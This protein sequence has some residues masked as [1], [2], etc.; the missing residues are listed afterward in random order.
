VTARANDR[1]TRRQLWLFVGLV[2]VLGIACLVWSVNRIATSASSGIGL[3]PVVLT[4]MIAVANSSG[5]RVRV[6]ASIF[7]FSVTSSAV[8]VAAVVEPVEW[9][10]VCAAAGVLISNLSN[11]SGRRSVE[12]TAFNV[13]K[14]SVAATAAAATLLAFAI[15]PLTVAAE[16]E[17]MPYRIF[18]MFVA[19][20]VYL[21]I[22]E[23]FFFPVLSSATGTP[24]RRLAVAHLDVRLVMRLAAFLL[25]V[26]TTM[27][28][29]ANRGLLIA[30]P[31]LLYALQLAAKGRV[32]SR[33]EREAWQNL[34]RSTDELNEVDLDRVLRSAIVRA[35]ELFSVDEVEVELAE[36]D[37]VR[38]RLVRGGNH[39][40][41]YDGPP[42][43][44]PA[45]K[46]VVIA[47]ELESHGGGGAVGEL[48]LRFRGKVKLSDR[49]QYTLHTFAAA[50]C[51]AI[52][53]AAAYAETQRLAESHA[54]AASQDPLTGLANRRRLYEYGTEVL[55]RRPARGIAGLLL[56]D[57]NHF[58]E[59]NDT[60]GHSAGDR[61]LQ[62][63]ARRLAAA[64]STEDLVARLGGDEFAVLL[65]GLPAPAVA[66][67]RAQ[68]MLA[69]LAPPVELD[70]MRI[71]VEA[72]AGVATA[73]SRG[74]VV[75]LLRRADV[76]MYQAKRDGQKVCAY[77][78]ARDTADVGS[79]ALGGDLARAVAEDQ[80][81]VNF[82]PIV[83]LGTGE[84]I[85]AEALTRWHHP[86]RG[87][88]PP[89][90]FLDAIE[91]SGRLPAFAEAVLDQAL[92][93]AAGWRA[94]GF[95]IPVAVNVSPRSL[96]DPAFPSV[97]TGR[98][99]AHR[100]PAEALVVELTESLTLSQ[101]DV[102]DEVLGAL[103][104][105]GVVLALD[106]FGTGYSSL[107][108]LARVPVHELKI[109]R[110]FVASMD[111]PVA[112]AVVRST[113]ELGR[114]LDLLVVAEGVESEEQRKKLW[115]LGCPAGQ[116]HLFARPMPADRLITALHRGS[117][118]R[119]GTLAP[120]LH[121]A[122][123]VIRMPTSRRGRPPSQ[124]LDRSG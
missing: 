53:N 75:E 15:P 76:A 25:A 87:D 63:V 109:D 96:L 124:R 1:A 114:S 50:L 3:Y 13:A 35:A 102:V 22:D 49:E 45:S 43:R 72:S 119:P 23:L 118:G 16:L 78:R 98:L 100:L 110:S 32:Q 90:R 59:V 58:K 48:R 37:I 92:T 2:V 39:G 94:E 51:T 80:F 61:V 82:Q 77:A 29:V 62:E 42:E 89:D 10:S 60:L 111:S 18:A 8:L 112:A 34:A 14:E 6:R 31:F 19:A 44:A 30:L 64:A 66:L 28:I 55:A 33:E 57:L 27:V 116:G 41:D 91:R 107:A 117:D 7:Q 88:L 101:L 123:A 106:D 85:A 70:G 46:G 26:I 17:Q 4:G 47:I 38:R 40:V 52:R 122:G 121:E 9:V 99:A 81:T 74:G 12:K 69:A 83:D 79:L 84:V 54:L 21:I 86:A 5:V 95:A 67:H 93:A 113:I 56:V 68:T 108:T 103:R 104:Q 115:E 73:A 71:T 97:V 20:V 11:P 65:V 24:I 105:A 36:S 120:P